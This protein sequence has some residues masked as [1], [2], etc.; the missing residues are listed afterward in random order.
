MN[1]QSN[2]HA[3]KRLAATLMGGETTANDIPGTTFAD[4]VNYIADNFKLSGGST[5]VLGTLTLTSVLGSEAGKTKITVTPELS[6]GNSYRFKTDPSAI[7]LPAR[8]ANLSDWASW[9]GTSELVAEDSHKICICEVD[10]SNR[11][12]KG[13]V[14]NIVSI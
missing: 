12:I 5:L 9:D 13:G 8:N 3:M 2:V 11:A 1:A 7:E 4:V 14:T 10:G 6:S